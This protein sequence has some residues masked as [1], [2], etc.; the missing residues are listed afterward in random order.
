MRMLVH[1]PGPWH[2]TEDFEGAVH[3]NELVDAGNESVIKPV[4]G[5]DRGDLGISTGSQE[6][7]A[8]GSAVEPVTEGNALLIQ[9]CPQLLAIARAADEFVKHPDSVSALSNLRRSLAEAPREFFQR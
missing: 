5:W 1:S 4:Q 8:P 3:K 6:H 2:W 9:S 7:A